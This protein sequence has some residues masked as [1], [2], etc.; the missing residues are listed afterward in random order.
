MW[1]QRFLGGTGDRMFGLVG[2]D[3]MGC[4]WGGA[5]LYC[6]IVFGTIDGSEPEPFSFQHLSG[7][8]AGGSC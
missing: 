8:D 2:G 5:D 6:C 7:G 3:S 1:K 4:G